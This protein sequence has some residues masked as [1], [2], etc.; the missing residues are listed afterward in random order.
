MASQSGCRSFCSGLRAIE[1]R[2]KPSGI[3]RRQFLRGTPRP[4][5]LPLRPPW[6][7]QLSL[8]SCTSC[9]DC[10]TACPEDILHLDADRKPAV[11][12]TETGCTF[13]GECAEAC[14][15]E[16]FKVTDG[17]AWNADVI[18]SASCLLQSGVSCQL[19]TDFCD[20]E[21][22]RFDMNHPPVGTLR[23][24]QETC[25]SCGMCV[26]ACPTSAISLKPFIRADAA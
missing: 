8:R 15:H 7:T 23:I 21:A 2:M 4:T 12:F 16:V 6:V 1:A 25:T 18:V 10:V 24:D 20:V 26:A 5:E 19:C 17:P 13:C 22:L 3:N 14:T 9:G 11:D